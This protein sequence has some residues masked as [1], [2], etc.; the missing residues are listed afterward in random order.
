MDLNVPPSP[1][2]QVVDRILVRSR[3]VD[4]M[5]AMCVV[6]LAATVANRYL[7]EHFDFSYRDCS[8]D[9][10]YPCVGD[11]GWTIK[12]APLEASPHWQAFVQRRI[13]SLDC[14]ALHELPRVDAGH[15]WELQRYLHASLSGLFWLNGPRRSVFVGYLTVMFGLTVLACYGLF[16]LGVSPV[17]ASLAVLPVIFSDL[18]LRNTIHPLEYVKAPFILGCLFFVG[19]IVRRELGLRGLVLSSLAAGV[20]VGLGI[21]FKPDVLMC[22]PVAVVVIAAFAPTSW[23]PWRRGMASVLFLAA[24]AL[25]GWPVLKAQF[26]GA[27]GSLLPVQVL[28]G[29]ERSFSDYYAQPSLYDY[30]IRFDDAHITYLI[31][32][33]NQR[34][35]GS[36]AVVLFY[37]K[38]MQTAATLLLIDLDRIFPGDF[39]L[40]TWAA[41]INILKLSR[42]G[43]PAALVVVPLLFVTNLRWGCCVV[44]LML[45]AVGYVSLV[46]QPKH[47]F[48]LEWVPWWFAAIAVEQGMMLVGT[49]FRHADSRSPARHRFQQWVRPRTP[50]V[51]ALLLLVVAV[52]GV[53]VLVRKYQ[54]SRVTALVDDY[55]RR[56][57]AERLATVTTMADDGSTRLIVEGLGS[58]PHSTP[59]VEDYLVLDV[60]CGASQD[61]DVTAVYEQPTSPR[62]QTAVPCSA[63]PRHWKLFWPVYQYPPS[64]RFERFEW[65]SASPLRVPSIRRVGDL[66]HAPLLLKLTVPDDY[67]ARRWYQTLRENFFFDPLGVRQSPKR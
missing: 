38:E 54:Q 49:G 28:G 32:S 36:E 41:I 24:V 1:G 25:S 31:N 57:S 11:F 19:M 42:F 60:E 3:S 45:S 35:H 47:F 51:A 56:S 67:Q 43:V 23:G 10:L 53:F 40:R 21:G 59:L 50:R 52:L 15:T 48:H 44:V 12:S 65:R 2:L 22:V 62:E 5:A 16:R 27:W 9:L 46:F 66:S 37:S 58:A 14:N 30:G 29:M 26:F 17:I 64:S 4:L 6:L 63:G 55:T 13:S 7:D 61:V 18:H 20:T 39:L 33:Y 34:V 8:E